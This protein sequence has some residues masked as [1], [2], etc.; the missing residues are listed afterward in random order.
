MKIFKSLLIIVSL[1]MAT[2]SAFGDVVLWRF[3]DKV[4]GEERGICYSDMYGNNP[5]NN[6]DWNSEVISE[7]DKSKYID[8]QVKQIKDKQD[9]KD[10]DKKN[11]K[12]SIRTKLN[13]LTKEELDVLLGETN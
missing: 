10:L 1:F 13:M 3:T 8:L 9:A 4:S 12:K 2:S 5:I 6:P 11:K 7:N